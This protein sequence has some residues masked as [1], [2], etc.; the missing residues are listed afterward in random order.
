MGT[1]FH[2]GILVA[3]LEL[4]MEEVGTAMDTTWTKPLSRRLGE[5]EVRV[6]FA[7]SGPPFLELIEGEPGS[8][9]DAQ[10]GYRIDHLA[11]WVDDAASEA[12]GLEAAGM[13]V[14]LDGADYS[15]PWWSY[16]R[17]PRT[18]LRFELLERSRQEQIAATHGLRL[19][20]MT[21]A[22]GGRR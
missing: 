18:E 3:D 10:G 13:P 9:W 4:A 8:P 5:W 20:D 6:A 16:H 21:A 14:E 7:A 2:V 22:E 12:A 15:G 11:R 19:A 1:F 17:G